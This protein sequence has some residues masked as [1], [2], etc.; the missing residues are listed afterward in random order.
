MRNATYMVVLLTNNRKEITD[1]ATLRGGHNAFVR[2]R[3][4]DSDS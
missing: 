1:L 4:Q 3:S 2:G